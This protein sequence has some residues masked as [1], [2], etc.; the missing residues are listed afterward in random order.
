MVVIA[1]VAMLRIWPGG[2][3]IAGS[4]RHTLL[5]AAACGAAFSTHYYCVFLG[6]PLI[7]T[8]AMASRDRGP[9]TV[10][11]ECLV[12]TLVSLVV[13]LLLSPFL[14]LEPAIAWRDIVANRE[15]VVDRAVESGAF[16]P[17]R[18]YG[19][20]LLWDA[21]GLPAVLLAVVGLTS[22]AW[23]RPSMALF[24]LAFPVPFFLF[25]TNTVPAS[26][27]LNPLVPFLAIFA[28]YGAS[29]LAQRLPRRAAAFW[30]L[31]VAAAAPALYESVRTDLFIRRIDT[32]TIALELIESTIPEG[33]TIALQPY[34]TPLQPTRES[35]V[36][37]LE[38]TLGS[39]ANPPPK[40]RLQLSQSPWP[41][42]AY[43]LVYLGRGLD[44]EKTY[45][46]YSEL[47]GPAGLQALRRHN[48]AYVVVKRYNSSDPD[49]LPFLAALA[50]E[51]RRLALVSPYRTDKTEGS[52]RAS[53][54]FLHN[55]DARIDA[56]LER[57][58]PALEIW[59]IDGPP[60]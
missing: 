15:I 22:M 56:A 12:A 16:S 39:A 9:M 10:L 59:R 7:A 25:I 30:V 11:R 60:P 54:P 28:G 3:S 18:R 41:A 52:E 50:R 55:T 34:S 33:A 23:T 29:A 38:R 27:Y 26:R 43:G 58:G 46:D 14:A 49:T 47:G 21:V 1:Y 19:E 51:G 2:G 42:P 17:V 6:I 4:R 20:M 57:P 36:S 32:R 45:V 40:F 31:A 13:F 37:A 5:A 8:V 35:L 24:L 53:E 48:V 44:S